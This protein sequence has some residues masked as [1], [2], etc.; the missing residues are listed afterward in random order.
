M[1]Y[2]YHIAPLSNVFL[3]MVSVAYSQL[4]S[5]KEYGKIRYFERET[6]FMQHVL[7]S[8]VIVILF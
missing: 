3:S 4:E 2:E 1:A 5:E 8:I 7:D 6:T